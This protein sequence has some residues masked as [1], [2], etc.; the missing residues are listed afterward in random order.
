[1]NILIV[2]S[3]TELISAAVTTPKGVYINK[4]RRARGAQGLLSILQRCLTA[5]GCILTDMQAIVLGIGPGSFTGLRIAC[6][7][8]KGL[9][10]ATRIPVI[11]ISSFWAIA[12]AVKN[13]AC[14][15]AIIA[16][17]RK[18]LIY[19]A[20]FKARGGILKQIIKP[21]LCQLS[22]FTADNQTCLFVTSDISLRQKTLAIEPRIHFY[23]KPVFPQAQHLLPQAKIWYNAKR[24]TKLSALEP[25]YLHAET[26]QIKTIAA[27]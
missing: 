17:A 23:E 20:R 4:R 14:D 8:A 22:T 3:S 18:N 2:E 9:S 12:E 21:T 6:A 26:C 11:G 1:M 24:F 25:L 15:I 7:A 16:D 5:S 13:K 27:T 19:G 10:I